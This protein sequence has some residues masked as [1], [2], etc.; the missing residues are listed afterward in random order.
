MTILADKTILIIGC[1]LLMLSPPG[2]PGL[3]QILSFLTCIIFTCF[4]S[5]C[6]PEFTGISQLPASSGK[7]CCGLCSLLALLTFFLEPLEYYLPFLVYEMTSLFIKMPSKIY[8]VLKT[9]GSDTENIYP[10][11]KMYFLSALFLSAALL[12]Q[13]CQNSNSA[14]LF[15][16][17]GLGFFLSKKSKDL[18]QLS[19]SLHL[20]RDTSM[21][22]QILLKQKNQNL[23]RQQDYEIHV[24][25]LK[26][27]NRI[28]REIHDNVGHMLSR[29]LLQAGALMAVNHQEQLKEPL[30]ALKL[31]LNSAMDAIRESVHDLHD[32]SIDLEN[33]IEELF[34]DFSRY[35]IQLDYDMG[36][37]VPP[38]IKYCFL[39]IV[40][41]SLSNISR[42]SNATAISITLREHPLLY[43]L[44]V[45]DNGTLEEVFEPGM[46][47]SNMQKRIEQF[48]G[49]FS[50][51]TN[52]G[53][54]IFASVPIHDKN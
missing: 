37:A 29:S 4:M 5:C 11:C 43:Q 38:S 50:V 35:Q 41:E 42:H 13:I 19:R 28:A 44:V 20:L 9:A 25:T 24:A 39:S 6:N 54:R 36:S 23:I 15:L 49:N 3:L 2:E 30:N 53:F 46:G 22:N 10:S 16:L 14:P 26:E 48:N 21:E 34:S 12:V 51:S 27:R 17:C 40:K 47:I 33:A 52:H 31:T 32:D 1:S 8:P 7:A 18:L 45:S